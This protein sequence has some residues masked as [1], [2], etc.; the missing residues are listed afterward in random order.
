MQHLNK[1]EQRDELPLLVVEGALL[2]RSQHLEQIQRDMNCMSELMT[3]L[4]DL[5]HTQQESIDQV[6]STIERVEATVAKSEV[7]ITQAARYQAWRWSITAG[8]V[9][10]CCGG[11]VG[12]V[13][14]LKLGVGMWSSAWMCSAVAGYC[15]YR[16]WSDSTAKTLS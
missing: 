7:A 6:E 8:V 3:S 11:P 15:S 10:A 4:Q 12:A 2:S 16:M 1:Q 5:V 13:A 14:G 9:G